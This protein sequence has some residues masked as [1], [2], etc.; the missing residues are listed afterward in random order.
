[1]VSGWISFLLY[2]IITRFSELLPGL[3]S[4][5]SGIR[6]V[7]L[8]F[9]ITIGAMAGQIAIVTITHYQIKGLNGLLWAMALSVP[10]AVAMGYLAGMVM[11]RAKGREMITSMILGFFANG[12]YQLLFLFLV[13]T[14]IP[15]KNRAMMLPEGV[16]L[17][18]TV[19]L[20]GVARAL[21]KLWRIT[22]AE[23]GYPW[24]LCWLWRCSAW[25]CNT[26]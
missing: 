24:V 19:D 6:R 15:M 17:R 23:S 12:L 14:V 16:G 1:M 2:E 13:G 7:G 22:T 20:Y 4:T 9:A 3:G 5:D 18:N 21:D 25:Y 8:N 10:L 26:L 11:N